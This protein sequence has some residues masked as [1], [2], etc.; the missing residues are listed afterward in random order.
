[1]TNDQNRIG[2]RIVKARE[3]SNL[4]QLELAEKTYINKSVLNRIEKGTRPARDVELLAISDATNVSVDYLL[5]KS[6]FKD[7]DYIKSHLSNSLPDDLT[8]EQRKE[9]SKFIDYIK[10]RDK[11]N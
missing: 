9:I 5:G 3:N 1:M 7:E 11:N 4:T 8:E 10:N 2:S 6:Q